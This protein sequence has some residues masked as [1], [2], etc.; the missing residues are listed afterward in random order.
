M[1]VKG[2]KKIISLSLCIICAFGMVGCGTSGEKTS[3]SSSS[4]SE[5]SSLLSQIKSKGKIVVGTSSGTG[6]VPYTF[7]DP[8]TNKIVG[9]DI[10]LA[11]AI[12]KE[13]GV[14]LEI[15]D[16]TF[17]AVLASIPTNKIDIAIAGICETEE[18]KKSVDFSDIYLNSEQKILIRK[19]DKDKL[20]T[21]N[22]F[23]GK[24][25]G[26]QK[27]TSQEKLANSE[28]T[29]ANVLAIEKVP[30]V[31]LELKN[32][33]IDGLVIEGVVAQQYML[34]NDDLTLSDAEFKD[35]LKPTAMAFSKGNDDFKEIVNKVIK[36][37]MDNG[38][39]DKWIKQYSE[40]AA[41]NAKGK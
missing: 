4:A 31:I 34:V 8:K 12:A 32:K 18:R 41:N 17:S 10:E 22:D 25:V 37:N 38:N 28:I 19:E 30:D 35:K 6:Y 7:T 1:K 2:I 24:S 11:N 13:I 20:K 23:K 39:I 9:I 27:A 21:L 26:A 14:D 5:S 3:S 33:K 36:E 40:L 15:Q 29:D 16:M